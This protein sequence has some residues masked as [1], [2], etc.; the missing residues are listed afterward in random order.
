MQSVTYAILLVLMLSSFPITG[1]SQKAQSLIVVTHEVLLSGGD[2]KMGSYPVGEGEKQKVYSATFEDR[3]FRTVKVPGEVQLELGLKG[4]DRYYQSKEL[5][6]INEKE[7]WYRKQFV[8]PKEERGK[9]LRLKFEGVDY[10]ATVWLN[11][12]RL[13]EHEGAYVAFSYDVS[14]IVKFGA[15]NTLVVKVT[16]PWVPMDRAFGEYLK[17]DWMMPDPTQVTFPYQPYALGPYWGGI[18]AY[19]NAAFPMGLFRDVNLIVSGWAVVD[20]MFVRTEGLAKDASANLEITG[21]IRNYEAQEVVAEL[22]L[23][24]EPENFSGVGLTLPSETMTLHPGENTFRQKVVVKDAHLWWTWDLGKQ[25]LYRLVA[26]ISPPTSTVTDTKIT[27]FGIR[28]ISRHP[29]MSYWL[30]GKRLFLKG[31]WYPMSDYFASVPTEETYVKD[32]VL[33]RSANLNHIVNFTVVEKPIFYDLCDQMGILVITELPFGQFGPQQALNP[34]YPRYEA[35]VKSALTQVEEI[36]VALRNHP[37]IIEWAAFAESHQK[38]NGGWGFGSTSFASYDYQGFSDEIGKLVAKL[39]AGAIYQPSLC[40]FGEQHFWMAG[41][42][43]KEGYNEH[44]NAEAGFVSEYGSLALPSSESLE[45]FLS[46]EDLWGEKNRT[47]PT[48]FNLPISIPAYS[49]LT[50]FEY[51]GLFSILSHIDEFIDRNIQSAQELVDDSQLYQAFLMKY[52]SEVYRRKVHKPINGIRVWAYTEVAPGIQ[53]GFVDYNRIPKMAYYSLRQA[54]EQFDLNFAYEQV[55]ESQVSGNELKIPVW[56][57]NEYRREVPVEVRCEIVNLQGQRVWKKDFEATVAG[58]ASQEV[59]EVDWVPPDTPGVYVLKGQAT[60][61]G[62]KLQ[63]ENRTYIKVTPKLL[64]RPARVLVIGEKK[65]SVPVVAMLRAM[66]MEVEEIDEEDFLQL[67]ALKDSAAIKNS[68]D[69]VWLASFDSIWKLLSKDE[70]EGLKQAVSEGLS[71][72][73]TGGPGSFH[74]GYGKGACLELTSLAEMLPV[75]SMKQNDLVYGET[76]APQRAGEMRVGRIT[77]IGASEQSAGWDTSL[78]KKYGLAGFNEVELKAGNTQI[79]AIAGRPLLVEGHYGRGRTLVFTGFTPEY[80]PEHAFWNPQV[81]FPY[82]VDQELYVNPESKA[83]FDVF[84]RMMAT[85][86]GEKP[87]VEYGRMLSAR[88]KPLFETLKEQAGT[89]L[90]VPEGVAAAVSGDEANVSLNIE[91]ESRYAHLVRVSAVWEAE[92]A[93]APYLVMYSD[94]YF[95]LLPGEMKAI[96]VRVLTPRGLTGTI[97]G[98][99]M[100]KGSNV[101]PAVVPITLRAE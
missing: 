87:A 21:T 58:D 85:A 75:N 46:P 100:V 30:N 60:E 34:S 52:A 82:L 51:A 67:K 64:R 57:V 44:F 42:G 3:G 4:M 53:W 20:D 17:G 61:V 54:L 83:Y 19:G 68:Y 80:V 22:K 1:K 35:F 77:E 10:Y 23:K 89:E 62:G 41:T 66:G 7:W 37:S 47:L 65:Y 99:F 101:S 5:S 76:T 36:I 49:Y 13:G 72:I 2:W 29:D 11:G 94:N 70:A 88:E 81:V 43:V 15:E 74:G 78:L 69:V 24:I 91:N 8:V 40:D 33:Y 73:H 97:K 59:G 39:D 26:A 31:A 63:A 92:S 32:L 25:N 12:E 86:T 50:S 93:K 6:T 55:L 45:K 9:L 56:I 48:W 98:K 96:D 27:K 95:D 28:T 14:P 79:L 16:C 71:F 18:P 84:M 90:K 38:D